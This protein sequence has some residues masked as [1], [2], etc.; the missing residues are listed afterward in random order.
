MLVGAFPKAD[1][2]M[3]SL[4]EGEKQ[5]DEESTEEQPGTDSNLDGKSTSAD[6]EQEARSN[7]ENIVIITVPARRRPPDAVRRAMTSTGTA[8]GRYIACACLRRDGC[9]GHRLYSEDDADQQPEV[10]GATSNLAPVVA[11]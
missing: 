3:P 11:R 8:P 10:R 5:C 6:S 9:L 2:L 7:D 4:T 1:Q